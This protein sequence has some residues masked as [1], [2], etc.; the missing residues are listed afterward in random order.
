VSDRIS[1][2]DFILGTVPHKGQVLNQIAAWWFVKLDE[3]DIPHHLISVPHP[4]ISLVKNVTVLPIEIVVRGYLTGTTKTSAW[5]AYEHLDRQICGLE[6][7]AGMQKNQVF[8]TPIVTP[9]TKPTEG[10]DIPISREE[11]LDQGL[12]VPE[13]YVQ[14][15]ACALKMFEFGQKVAA[16]HGLI[17]VDTKYEMGIDADGQ[18]LVIDEVHT[19]DSSRYWLADNYEARFAAGEEPDSLDKEFVR[20]LIVDRGYDVESDVDPSQFMD[21]DLRVEAAGKYLDLYEKM[22]GKPLVLDGEVDIESILK[23]LV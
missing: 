16:E 3:I 23:S 5:Y 6:M 2:F 11:I 12:V 19:P 8:D 1:A 9:T 10:H 17:L 22:T 15:E 20:R 14:A 21:D 18:L 4:N 13:I 7:P